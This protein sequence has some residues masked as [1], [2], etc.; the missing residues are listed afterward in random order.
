[1]H[2]H[3]CIYFKQ[4]LC[5]YTLKKR[6]HIAVIAV[7]YCKGSA[8]SICKASEVDFK[9]LICL[10]LLLSYIKSC[11]LL[12]GYTEKSPMI[13]NK[14]RYCVNFCN[15]YPAMPDLRSKKSGVIVDACSIRPSK[16]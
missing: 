7:S 15:T 5:S 13:N 16:P 14:N 2:I 4:R 1:M 9:K 6:P 11:K 10:P 12:L 3:S 8:A